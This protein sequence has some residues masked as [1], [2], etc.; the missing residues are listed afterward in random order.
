VKITLLAMDE[1]RAREDGIRAEAQRATTTYERS[2]LLAK[3]S[4]L[5]K[6]RTAVFKAFTPAERTEKERHDRQRQNAT[7][8]AKVTPEKL[9]ER[10][11]K[12]RA[13]K[14]AAAKNDQ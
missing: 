12:R 11:M 14:E 1:L 2:Q 10:R 7:A 4:E 13:K 6:E 9:E 8:Q 5:Y 3:A